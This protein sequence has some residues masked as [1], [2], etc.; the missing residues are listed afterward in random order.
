[1]TRAQIKRE[2]D[3]QIIGDWIAPGSRV[4][5][6]GCGRGVLLDYLTQKKK[7]HGLGVDVDAAKIAECLRRGLS[8]YHGDANRLLAEFPAGSWDWVILSRTLQELEQPAE[9][10]RQALGVA[11]SLAVG[12]VNYG[13][14]RNRLAALRTG[15]LPRNEV[16]PHSWDA[17]RPYNPI[18][19][20]GFEDFC[21]REGL[22]IRRRVY[23]RGDWKT[24]LS[25]LPNL[26]AGYALYEVGRA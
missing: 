7:I 17:N 5:D 20:A 13:Y 1:M 14:W 21:A 3:L 24:P 9:T 6:I 16:F 2:T 12:F 10:L 15:G 4:I 23:L 26:R 19:I 11:R 8:A 18:T 22:A 25:T